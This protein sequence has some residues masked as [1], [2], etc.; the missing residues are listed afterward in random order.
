M[1]NRKI[2]VVVPVY[3]GERT[4]KRC[5]DSIIKQTYKNIEIV[6]VNDGSVD[7]TYAICNELE[8]NYDFIKVIN[9]KNEGV[10]QARN[11]GINHSNGDYIIFVDGD[12]T[13]SYNMCELLLTGIEENKKIMT[14]CGMRLVDEDFNLIKSLNF[15]NILNEKNN[16]IYKEDYLLIFKEELLNSPCNKLFSTKIIKENN[17]KFDS[18]LAIG[19]DLLFVMNYIKYIDKF[20][21]INEDLYNYIKTGNESL[22][23]KVYKDMYTIQMRIFD[24]LINPITS[25]QSDKIDIKLIKGVYYTTIW[26]SIRNLLRRSNEID[27]SFRIKE[28][29][30]ILLG[31]KRV[32][33]HSDNSI[34]KIDLY[35]IGS[36]LWYVKNKIRG[37]I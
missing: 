22:S 27:I 2:S 33:L 29:I 35:N 17:L 20:Y 14:I 1:N 13:V 36:P 6:I 4:I 11:T 15:N 5:I 26:R 34:K 30:N 10:S 9:K 21:V 25:G 19:E 24:S 23:I 28:L 7:N 16:Y 37:N 3:N 31:I 18:K 32:D 12:D 8:K